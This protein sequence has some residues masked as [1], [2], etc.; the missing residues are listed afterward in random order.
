[1]QILTAQRNQVCAA[2]LQDFLGLIGVHDHAYCHRHHIGAAP[3]ASRVLDLVSILWR[4]LGGDG[5]RHASRTAIDDIDAVCFECFGKRDTVLDRP[6]S[7][8]N[9]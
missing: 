9:G 7:L 8:I 1:M 5:V 4:V 2:A 3:D 6:A